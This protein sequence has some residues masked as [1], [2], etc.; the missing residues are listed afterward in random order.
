MNKSYILNF[1]RPNENPLVSVPFQIIQGTG[2]SM[3][4]S[5][6]LDATGYWTV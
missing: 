2:S 6:D 1:Y 5:I 4:L 3:F